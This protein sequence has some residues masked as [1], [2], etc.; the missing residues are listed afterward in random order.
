MMWFFGIGEEL[1]ADYVRQ[2][3]A[4]IHE[5]KTGGGIRPDAEKDDLFSELETGETKEQK[6]YLLE[7]MLMSYECNRDDILEG[8]QVLWNNVVDHPF[9]KDKAKL[10][11]EKAKGAGHYDEFLSKFGDDIAA[12]P[13]G[14]ERRISHI[15]FS[16]GGV[17]IVKDILTNLDSVWEEK[18]YVS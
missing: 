7:K 4:I 3:Q 13:S 6:A 8:C 9:W 1:E 12:V 14:S 5:I 2:L 15:K 18:I 11:E 10:K 16:D 17:S